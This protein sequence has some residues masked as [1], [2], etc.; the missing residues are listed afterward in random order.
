[1]ARVWLAEE[2]NIAG[3]QVALKEPLSELM[4]DEAEEVKRRYR[5]EVRVCAALTKAKVPNIVNV[6]AGE[7]YGESLL[8]VME[9]MPAGT[10]LDLT[11]L[12]GG[13]VVGTPLYAAP[14][15]CVARGDDPFVSFAFVVDFVLQTSCASRSAGSRPAHR[16]GRRLGEDLLDIVTPGQ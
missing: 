15:T 11:K 3:R 16:R 8:L 2:P 14:L 10:S 7:P 6:I 9:Y 12:R 13:G 4:P 5:R 1:M